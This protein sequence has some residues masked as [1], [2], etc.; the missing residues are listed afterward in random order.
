M[1]IYAKCLAVISASLLLTV[2]IS[3]AQDT[4]YVAGFGGSVETAFVEKI[5][6]SFEATSGIKVVYVAGN[7]TDTV[8]KLQAQKD[9]PELSVAIVDDGPMN[10][11]IQ[12]GL[13]APLAAGPNSNAVYP[14]ARV[15]GDFAI[16]LGYGATGLVY[17]TEVFDKNGWPA[18]TSWK[19][20]EDPKYAGKIIIPPISN[21]FGLLT[22]VMQARL[23]GGSERNIDP[24]FEAMKRI[25]PG[26]L[27]FEPN[28]GK[29]AELLQTGEAALGVW[30][31]ARTAILAG[32]GAPVKFVYPQ[33]GAMVILSQVCAVANA[34]HPEQAQAF[35]QHLLSPEVQA[36]FTEATG[37]GPVNPNTK[38]APEVEAK[39][40]FGEDKVKSLQSVDYSV[41]NPAR[42]GWT[43]RWN[44]EIER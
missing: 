35:I 42:A 36:I 41:I 16:G 1:Q 7:S 17:N 6:P 22:L 19:D 40:V 15:E 21:G 27:A 31:N 34:P 44:R 13:C 3:S 9:N 37:L 33:E 25:K 38:L 39:V 24:G 29:I 8:A 30:N 5:I 43:D 12:A 26:V 4:M 23:N 18:P 10:T 20:L 11:A 32:Q 28:P 2:G 14:S